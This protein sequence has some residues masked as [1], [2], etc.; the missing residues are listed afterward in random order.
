M[1]EKVLDPEALVDPAAALLKLTLTPE[2]RAQTILH[3]T[4]AAEQA[5]VLMSGPIGDADEPAPVYQP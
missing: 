1:M 2:S 5:E 3:L 4:I